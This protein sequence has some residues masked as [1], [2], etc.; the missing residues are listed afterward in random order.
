MKFPRLP[1]LRRQRRKPR[2]PEAE[3]RRIASEWASSPEG[4]QRALRQAAAMARAE[5]REDLERVRTA[6]CELAA[7]R[8][9]ADFRNAT[10]RWMTTPRQ[11]ELG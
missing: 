10:A 6:A 5:D 4:L 7:E 9:G 2:L 8:F 11:K 1:Q 3:V